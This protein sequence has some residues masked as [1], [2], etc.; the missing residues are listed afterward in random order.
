LLNARSYPIG[1]PLRLEMDPRRTSLAISRDRS[2]F[3]TLTTQ[4]EISVGANM[5]IMPLGLRE[6]AAVM[7][8]PYLIKYYCKRSIASILTRSGWHPTSG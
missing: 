7:A 6:K 5:F 2:S 1:Q 4:G 3:G 8:I